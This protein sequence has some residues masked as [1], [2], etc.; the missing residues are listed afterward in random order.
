MA[1]AASRS[2][3][4]DE[5]RICLREHYMHVV[6]SGDEITEPTLRAV[7]LETG[8]TEDDIAA[9]YDEGLRLREADPSPD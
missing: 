4:Y 1:N 7:L 9:F 6:R 8:F 3:F 5:W 2:E